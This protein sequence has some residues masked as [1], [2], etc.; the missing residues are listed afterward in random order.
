M[1]KVF[2]SSVQPEFKK[3][4]LMLYDFLSTDLLL[5]KFFEPFIFE[6]VPALNAKPS[7]VFLSEVQQSDIY[8]GLLGK[9]YGYEDSEGMSPT[10]REYDCATETCKARYIFVKKIET[11]RNPKEIEFIKKVE[12]SVIRKTFLY[13]EDLKA[14]VYASLIRYLEEKEYIRTTP[15]DATFNR[16]AKFED[17][18]EKKVNAFARVANIKRSFPFNETSDYKTVLSHLNLSVENKIT[19]AALLLFAKD[20][21]KFLIT[22]TVKCCQFYGNKIEKPIP[23]YHIYYG[24]V[25]QLI[26]QALSFVMSR[27]NAKVGARDKKVFVDVDFELPQDAIKE[28]I[29]NAICHRD[30]TSNASIQIMLF[31]NRLEIWNPGKLPYGLTTEMLKTNNTSIPTNPLLARPMYMFGSIEQVGTGT[32]MIVDKCKE[33]G[34]DTPSFTQ[35]EDFKV[36]FWRIVDE[37]N[38]NKDIENELS[39]NQQK[40]LIEISK[41]ENITQKELSYIIGINEKNIR[42][43]INK[44][45]SKGIIERIGPDKGGYWKIS[46]NN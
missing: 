34:L 15:F 8:I 20:P 7:D 17:I 3:E 13:P 30:Y 39:D 6:K 37:E 23:S 26:D 38:E 16:F 2:I 46:T 31:R 5:G 35:K 19:N 28:A 11:E 44:L 43:N 12:Q 25:F 33:F 32:E 22:S 42:I 45:K 29:V 4:R 36:T 14:S 41:N 1:I 21:Q 18:D 10:E 9:S 27:I 24:D 40:I